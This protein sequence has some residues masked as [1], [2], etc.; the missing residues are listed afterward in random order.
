MFAA[1][2]QSLP[3]YNHS[4]KKVV[5]G[6]GIDIDFWTKNNSSAERLPVAE[7]VSV[8]RICRSKRIEIG[9]LAL[10]FLPVDYRLTIYGRDVEKDYFAELKQLVKD[11]NLEARVNFAGPVP[12]AE[13]KNIYGRYRLLV[14]MASETI[15]KTMLEAMLFGLYPVTTKGNSQAIGLPVYPAD[16]EP[17]TIAHFILDQTWAAYGQNELLAIIKD[18][19][20]LPALVKNMAD[21]IRA[22]N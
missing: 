6:H 9:I 21:Y 4:S 17:E 18:K 19:H 5:L 14:N 1:T 8:H 11:N 2:A 15:D 22:G 20:S 12:M 13:L 10:K 16:D 7:L 3:Q